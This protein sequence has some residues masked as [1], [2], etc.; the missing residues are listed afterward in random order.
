MELLLLFMGLALGVSFTCSLLEAVLLS[1]TPSYA[2]ALVDQGHPAGQRLARLKARI[3][4]PLAAILSLNTIANT[5]GAVAVGAQAEAVFGSEWVGLLSAVMT[6]LILVCSEILP[7]SLGAA[8]WRTLAPPLSR[9]LAFLTR[10]MTPFVWLSQAVTG[11]FGRRVSP[12]VVSR[13]ELSA[14]AAI[15]AEHGVFEEGESK[16]LT[17]LLRME[18]LRAEDIMTPRTVVYALPASETVGGVVERVQT[19]PFS[20]ILVFRDTLDEVAGYVLKGDVLLRAARDEVAVPLAELTRELKPVPASL[21]LPVLFDDLLR[22]GAPI[23]LVVDEYG[24]TAGV[25]T[26]EDLVETLLGSEIVDEAD[27]HADMQEL[28]RLR[29]KRRAERLGIRVEEDPHA[30]ARPAAGAPP[31]TPGGPDEEPRR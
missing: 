31:R 12:V 5:A 7:K 18:K 13:A 19:C 6:L 3:D 20:R 28:A 2:A 30:A 26:L 29:W 15:G 14:M 9:F 24:G 23:A 21:P 4:R 22:A 16:I 10:A 1:V 8:H 11:L 27:T 25:V 17:N